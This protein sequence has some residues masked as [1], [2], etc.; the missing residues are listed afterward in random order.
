MQK[1][2]MKYMLVICESATATISWEVFY[3]VLM[4]QNGDHGLL[5][6]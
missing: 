3:L 1:H 2:N 5:A 6:S 4:P